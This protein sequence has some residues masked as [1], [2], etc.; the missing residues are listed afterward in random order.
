MIDAPPLLTIRRNVTR[1]PAETVAKLAGALTGNI[2]DCLGGR[3]AMDPV[4]KPLHDAPEA[5][6]RVIGPAFPCANG[7]ADQLALVGALAQAEPGDV[8]VVGTDGY[9]GTAVV[10][11][12]MLGMAR[13]RGLAGIVTDGAVRDVGGILKVGLPVFCAGVNPNSP[14]RNGPGTV[15]FAVTMGGVT[16]EA[17]DVVVGDRDGVV[18]VPRA[19]L[20]DVV[21][22]LEAIRAKEA[23]M[24][25]KVDAGLAL[26]EAWRTLLESERIH[27]VD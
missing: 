16:V 2:A 14:A 25:A 24:E 20:D 23:D 5:M 12:L 4:I 11:D 9:T 7:P 21:T 10:G 1:P 26:P 15:G 27:Y 17:G 3:G 22:A 18:I 6:R 19:Q 13:N 8:L